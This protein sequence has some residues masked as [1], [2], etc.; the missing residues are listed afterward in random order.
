MLLD[1]VKKR[2]VWSILR[3][4]LY[5]KSPTFWGGQGQSI[6]AFEVRTFASACF[7]IPSCPPQYHVK[8]FIPAAWPSYHFIL[9]KVNVATYSCCCLNKFIDRAIKK[10]LVFLWVSLESISLLSV[11][12]HRQ[13]WWSR[14][15]WM[16]V[17]SR[18]AVSDSL[19][20]LLVSPCAFW[21]PSSHTA[22]SLS[23]VGGR[24]QVS[25]ERQQVV[26]NDS[27]PL[28]LWLAELDLPDVRES[29][30]S[31]AQ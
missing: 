29:G 30:F 5:N 2:S 28:R 12:W 17:L 9:F 21:E 18:P 16:K 4:L 22:S 25:S 24:P 20:F 14:C 15:C 27:Q 6:Q 3:P 31:S 26:C 23:S 7:L 1:S 10:R 8:P 11:A 13:Q 19:P